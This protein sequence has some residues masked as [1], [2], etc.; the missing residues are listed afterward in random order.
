A[1]MRKSNNVAVIASTALGRIEG[2]DQSG[3]LVFRA[4]PYATPPVGGLRFRAPQPPQPWNSV[5]NGRLPGPSAPQNLGIMRDV[6][7]LGEDCLQLNVWTPALHGRRPV[8]VWV[9]G[10]AFIFGASTHA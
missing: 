3:V 8:L 2:E 5:R 1:G 4:I 6:P 9:H 7:A 10:G